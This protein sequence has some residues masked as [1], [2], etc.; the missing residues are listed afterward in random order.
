M[1]PAV[2]TLY[3]PHLTDFDRR[4]LAAAAPGRDPVEAMGLPE[5]EQAVFAPPASTD[6]IP[7]SP[8]LTFAVA[9][10]RC[11]EELASATYVQEWTGPRQRIPVFDVDPLREFL[12]DPLHR[13]FMVELLASYTHVSSGVRWERTSR[14]WRRRRFSELDPLRLAEMLEAV[15]PEERPGVYRRLGDLALFLTGVFPD[16]TALRGPTGAGAEQLVRITGL[17]REEAGE[18]KGLSLLE[19][20]GSHW[21]RMASRTVAGVPTASLAVV[22][23]FG[24][25]FRDAR[26][27]LNVA[28]DR[29]LFPLRQRWFGR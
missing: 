17:A 19:L 1:S 11:A 8:F 18:L 16:H 26:R 4:L 10:H 12:A 27:I 20:L 21:Y 28:T 14:G 3:R 23:D 6:V 9:V 25:R 24:R 15:G 2:E 13:F 5:V 29:F 7:A 22:A